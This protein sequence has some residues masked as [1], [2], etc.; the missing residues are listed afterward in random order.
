MK[1]LAT[2][3]FLAVLTAGFSANASNVGLQNFFYYFGTPCPCA[4]VAPTCEPTCAPA[5][6]EPTCCPG[7][8][9]FIM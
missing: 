4:M 7:V 8:N 2:V 3:A 1:A 5:P 6:V 9:G